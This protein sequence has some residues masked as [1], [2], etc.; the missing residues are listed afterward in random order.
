MPGQARE[1]ALNNIVCDGA[2]RLRL[3]GQSPSP[4]ESGDCLKTLEDRRVNQ[5]LRHGPAEQPLDTPDAQVHPSPGPTS[6]DHRLPDRFQP[7]RPELA[8]LGVAME[9]AEGSEAL[10]KVVL[11][12]GRV[13]VGV[14]V[15]L[16]NEL[17]PAAEYEFIH[18]QVRDRSR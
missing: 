4:A 5:F 13:S 2:N 16:G 9:F 1:G 11:L 7:L 14:P 17:L 18:S 6:V 3:S 8:G 15:V 10:A 12:R